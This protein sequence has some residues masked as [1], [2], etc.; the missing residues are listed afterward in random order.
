MEH[1]FRL[2]GLPIDTR[3]PKDGWAP[4]GYVSRCCDCGEKF[5]GAKLAVQCSDCAYKE[6]VV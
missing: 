6:S 1:E 3:A 4:G 2:L 5:V